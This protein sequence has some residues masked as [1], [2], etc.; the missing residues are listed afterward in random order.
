MHTPVE[1]IRRQ[2]PAPD[3]PP[4]EP[5]LPRVRSHSPMPTDDGP[6]DE[7]PIMH[8]PVPVRVL[9]PLSPPSAGEP[10]HIRYV[11]IPDSPP[12]VAVQMQ[13]PDLTSP[14]NLVG[15]G[16]KELEQR[17]IDS[18][19]SFARLVG[20]T[21]DVPDRPMD[22]EE[23]HIAPGFSPTAQMANNVV[24]DGGISDEGGLSDVE[25]A[26]E[27]ENPSGG[28]EED[29]MSKMMEMMGMLNG[30]PT[31]MDY[32]MKKMMEKTKPAT[33]KLK[34]MGMEFNRMKFKLS[35]KMYL[36]DPTTQTSRKYWVHWKEPYYKWINHS[37]GFPMLKA[38]R[39]WR[40]DPKWVMQA[41]H[42][43]FG[44]RWMV[45]KAKFDLKNPV[46]SAVSYAVWK[47]V[48]NTDMLKQKPSG[49]RSNRQ[50]YV[51]R[52]GYRRG[53]YRRGGYR[54]SYNRFGGGF[55]AGGDVMQTMMLMNMMNN[56]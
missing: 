22:V 6:P 29:K 1:S 36:L 5:D 42:D 39:D 18:N 48:V 16:K 38:T 15:I 8:R 28:E 11:E 9:P 35:T 30:R 17:I 54:G 14:P 43:S 45:P 13:I 37:N 53:G 41:M 23:S 33:Y 4:P 44:T 55:G 25:I 19:P 27:D 40:L 32:M 50:S 46:L 3:S 26:A 51:G 56:K 21:P 47:T 12:S 31:S 24:W 52:G 2:I 49:F 34:P 20:L 7:E 10:A